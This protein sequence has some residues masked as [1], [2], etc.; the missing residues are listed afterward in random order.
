M[1]VEGARLRLF[2]AGRFERLPSACQAFAASRI[3]R[4]PIGRGEVW[5]VGDA[6]LLF[7]PLW[8]GDP[9]WADH[10]RRAD[11]MEWLA[12]RLWPDA[13]RALLR[14]LWARLPAE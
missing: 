10:L 2:S 12:A 13:P 9:V 1:D 6:D 8:Q 3:A 11:T 7:A 14:P 5:L 4:C